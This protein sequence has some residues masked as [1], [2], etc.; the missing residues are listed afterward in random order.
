MIKTPQKPLAHPLFK[1]QLIPFCGYTHPYI[2]ALSTE[3][4]E[5]PVCVHS[6]GWASIT[7]RNEKIKEISV[8]QHFLSFSL[9]HWSVNPELDAVSAGSPWDF[10]VSCAGVKEEGGLIWMESFVLNSSLTHPRFGSTDFSG[11]LPGGRSQ[12]VYRPSSPSV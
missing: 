4:R 5:L 10:C 2:Q 8:L 11:H 3:L 6:V 1:D 9:P 12:L 7:S